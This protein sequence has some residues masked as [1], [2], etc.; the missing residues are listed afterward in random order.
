MTQ[1]WNEKH[2]NNRPTL[3]SY[4]NMVHNN[5]YITKVVK[6]FENNQ[7][8]IGSLILIGF[9]ELNWTILMLIKKS[10]NHPMRIFILLSKTYNFGY[11]HN[12]I[13]V[14]C[15]AE[16]LFNTYIIFA[17][18]IF[19]NISIPLPYLPNT[20]IIPEWFWHKLNYFSFCW[21]LLVVSVEIFINFLWNR[22]LGL[23]SWP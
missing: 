1:E 23:N 16:N 8:T 7:I 10:N 9:K 11:I 4:H 21:K 3:S 18:L 14:I 22:L 2:L 17:H 6:R 5:R 20:P 19:L 15:Q 12:N 13:I